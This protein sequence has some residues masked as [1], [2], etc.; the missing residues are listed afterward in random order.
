MGGTPFMPENSIDYHYFYIFLSVYGVKLD[1]KKPD[2]I[3]SID[4]SITPQFIK[5]KDQMDFLSKFTLHEALWRR[6]YSD[7][8]FNRLEVGKDIMPFGATNVPH[9]MIDFGRH[10]IPRSNDTVYMSLSFSYW[11]W[12]EQKMIDADTTVA[13]SYQEEKYTGFKD[14]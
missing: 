8:A 2:S 12:K 13:M 6:N 7:S 11:S 1:D 3:F 9:R 14:W 5:K 4:M 10:C